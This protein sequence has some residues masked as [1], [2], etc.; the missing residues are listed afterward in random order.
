MAYDL[1]LKRSSEYNS[2]PSSAREHRN[3][4]HRIIHAQ[5]NGSQYAHMQGIQMLTTTKYLPVWCTSKTPLLRMTHSC[6]R[7]G[8][9]IGI[10]NRISLRR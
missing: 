10:H 5:L 7:L 4:W 6:Q 3:E 8:Y 2:A 1:K 9:Y